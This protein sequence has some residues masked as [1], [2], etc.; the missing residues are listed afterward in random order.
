MFGFYLSG[1]YADYLV[2]KELADGAEDGDGLKIQVVME[3]TNSEGSR[4]SL[5]FNPPADV[6]AN[7]AQKWAVDALAMYISGLNTI[8]EI[9]FRAVIVSGHVTI[10]GDAVD[11][12]VS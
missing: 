11:Y 1:N 7:Y 8:S 9:S 10:S 6:V 4:S 12:V 3:Y 5:T 2:A